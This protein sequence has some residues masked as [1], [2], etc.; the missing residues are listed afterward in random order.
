MRAHRSITQT[1]GDDH[2]TSSHTFAGIAVAAAVLVAG[3][4]S[5]PT[6]AT[7]ATTATVTHTTAAPLRRLWTAGREQARAAR[8]VDV[9]ARALRDGDVERLCRPGAVFTS[10]VVAE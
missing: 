5:S 9:L 10:A 8:A 6:G 2:E 3:C 1:R 4:G 7:D